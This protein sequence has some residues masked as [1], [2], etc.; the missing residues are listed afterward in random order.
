[1]RITERILSKEWF[2]CLIESIVLLLFLF[3]CMI[4]NTSKIVW[5]FFYKHF[6]KFFFVSHRLKLFADVCSLLA[7]ESYRNANLL[8]RIKEKPLFR[9][10]FRY[11]YNSQIEVKFMANTFA[12]QC[13]KY[14]CKH[15][16][17]VIPRNLPELVIPSQTNACCIFEF[18][19]MTAKE[20]WLAMKMSSIVHQNE[21]AE[22]STLSS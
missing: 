5:T 11:P 17:A 14:E 13:S 2:Q 16:P 22:R 21:F 4:A 7:Y 6:F 3:V 10:F 15:S 18:G 1:M 19:E 9:Y 20:C 8:Q 12:Y